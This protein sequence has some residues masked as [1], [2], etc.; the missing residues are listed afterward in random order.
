MTQW[1]P[2]LLWP[3]FHCTSKLV[4]WGSGLIGWNP[5]LLAFTASLFFLLQ[6]LGVHGASAEADLSYLPE[7][8]EQATAAR[9]SGMACSASLQPKLARRIHQHAG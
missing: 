7:L 1:R 2:I 4:P 9:L 8:I 5:R 3:K 6:V